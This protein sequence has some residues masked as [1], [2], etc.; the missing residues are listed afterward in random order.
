MSKAD[1]MWLTIKHNENYEVSNLG[2]VRNKKTKRILRNWKNSRG[3]LIIS[4]RK[5]EKQYSY[6]IHRLVAETFIDNPNN[7]PQVNHIDGNKQNNCVREFRMVQ[8]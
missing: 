1:E 7:L 4:I 3:Y 2:E 5:R 8:C 6:T